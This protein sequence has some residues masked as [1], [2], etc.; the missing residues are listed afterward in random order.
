MGNIGRIDDLIGRL[1]A[2]YREA[3]DVFDAYIADLQ[4]E[5]PGVPFG[6]L[7]ANELRV[8]PALDYV[9]ALRLLRRKLGSQRSPVTNKRK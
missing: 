9:A 1:E 4:R 7:K 8:P 5:S 6:I 3:Q 2:T